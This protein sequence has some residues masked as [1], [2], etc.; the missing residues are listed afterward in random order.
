[1]NT[2]TIKQFGIKIKEEGVDYK[3]ININPSLDNDEDVEGIIDFIREYRNKVNWD[4]IILYMWLKDH[5]YMQ[6]FRE[7]YET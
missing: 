3:T 1:M 5:N 4:N 7:Y 2:L 6:E